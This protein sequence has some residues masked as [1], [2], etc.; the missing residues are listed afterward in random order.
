MVC[1]GFLEACSV[2]GPSETVYMPGGESG[3]SLP[4]LGGE[5]R[6]RECSSVSTMWCT[7][8][9]KDS[10]FRWNLTQSKTSQPS[11]IDDPTFHFLHEILHFLQ[12]KTPDGSLIF[13]SA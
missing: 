1:R 3:I 2:F 10:L 5:K 4:L 9:Y 11:N 7:R 6:E 12:K 8:Y 13:L